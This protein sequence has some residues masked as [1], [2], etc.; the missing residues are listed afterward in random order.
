MA[1]HM[2]RGIYAKNKMLMSVLV[3][4]VRTESKPELVKTE[5]GPPPSPASTC[6]DTSSIA[7]SASL[8]YSTYTDSLNPLAVVQGLYWPKNYPVRIS[9]VILLISPVV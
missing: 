9:T 5:M 2:H 4:V 3:L 8:P 1:M 7:S 6:S